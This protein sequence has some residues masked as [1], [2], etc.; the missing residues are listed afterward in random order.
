M[1]LK[2]NWS[3]ETLVAQ[4]VGRLDGESAADFERQI[5]EEIGDHSLVV[6]FAE[7]NYIS[8]AGLRVIL[9]LA[10]ALKA[11]ECRLDLC[12]LS[13][14]IQEVFRISGFDQIMNIH[15]TRKQALAAD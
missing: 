4:P 5:T 15:Q 3:G 7:L 14:P 10:K 2:L 13:H 1:E 11:R 8:S 6:D 9:V 12:C